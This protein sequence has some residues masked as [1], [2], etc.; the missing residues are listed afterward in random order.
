MCEM[1]ET[2]FIVQVSLLHHGGV[3]GHAYRIFAEHQQRLSG[4][5]R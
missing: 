3:L 1:K 5:H 4:A 2:A